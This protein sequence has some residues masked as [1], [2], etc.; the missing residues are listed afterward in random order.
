MIQGK[1]NENENKESVYINISPWEPE[2][3]GPT[4][5]RPI[6]ANPGLSFNLGFFIPLFKGLF[7]IVSSIP[8]RTFRHQIVGKKFKPNI[9]LKL[10]DM[11]SDFTLTLGYLN[12]A[13]NNLAHTREV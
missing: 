3:Q 4:V 10:S 2:I 5:R 1:K 13:L 11:R 7:H 6:S 12:L 9:L 8:F